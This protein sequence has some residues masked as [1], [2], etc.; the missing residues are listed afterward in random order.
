MHSEKCNKRAESCAF[1]KRVMEKFENIE[2]KCSPSNLFAV[3]AHT[4]ENRFSSDT[5]QHRPRK[6]P[7]KKL[8]AS[9]TSASL[10]IEQLKSGFR[11]SG[12]FAQ[13]T[14]RNW[15]PE[16]WI[17]YL[18]DN[19]REKESSA[20]NRQ[21][22]E[23]VKN[24]S[25]NL[26]PQSP[27][28]CSIGL[29]FGARSL[30]DDLSNFSS[31]NMIRNLKKRLNN[32]RRPIFTCKYWFAQATSRSTSTDVFLRA[33]KS[34]Q[35][36]PISRT[37]L[38]K[39]SNV[40]KRNEIPN[41]IDR[42]CQH[43]EKED[44][45]KSPQDNYA[46]GDRPLV[47]NLFDNSSGPGRDDGFR[48]KKKDAQIQ[49]SS[50]KKHTRRK[51]TKKRPKL[52]NEE[53]NDSYFDVD[54]CDSS[55]INEKSRLSVR[56]LQK[57]RGEYVDKF[58]AV[59]RQIEEITAALRETCCS[60]TDS[61]NNDEF[62]CS[63]DKAKP[64]KK[65][66]PENCANRIV[67]KRGT[68]V[69]RKTRDLTVNVTKVAEKSARH[70]NRKHRSTD[71][72]MNS[73]RNDDVVPRDC[74]FTIQQK[75]VRC[76][77][78]TPGNTQNCRLVRQISFDLDLTKDDVREFSL[79]DDTICLGDYFAMSNGYAKDSLVRSFAVES[80]QYKIVKEKTGET[81]ILN[82]IK[83]RID[84]DFDDLAERSGN[85][86]TEEFL[87]T[88][89]P[90]T[91]S[92]NSA[93]S[94]FKL[95]PPS[96][97]ASR[98]RTIDKIRSVP[99]LPASYDYSTDRSHIRDSKS[100]GCASEHESNK[101]STLSKYFSCAQLSLSLV[102]LDGNEHANPIAINDSYSS[103]NSNRY[104]LDLNVER[105]NLNSTTD[106]EYV[107]RY[108]TARQYNSSSEFPIETI[109]KT[110][111][112]VPVEDRRVFVKNPTTREHF[113]LGERKEGDNSRVERD[114][115]HASDFI[116]FETPKRNVG[117]SID[118]GVFSSSLID[119]YPPESSSFSAGKSELKKKRCNDDRKLVA[120]KSS[121][122]IF[123][124]SSDSSCT[125]N[126]LDRRVDDV[127]RDLTKNLILCE[128]RARAK[129]K[130]MRWAGMRKDPRCSR[131]TRVCKFAS[132][133]FHDT[134]HDSFI[135]SRRSSEDEEI[136]SLSTPSLLSDSENENRDFTR[137]H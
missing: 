48:V 115:R 92:D 131:H 101:T 71:L 29:R 88:V 89:S 25:R 86:T 127:V 65:R 16:F 96:G 72:S 30:S 107:A 44:A 40:F 80:K 95:T 120:G 26:I 41:V 13:R 52:M 37:S 67:A 31:Y 42:L 56:V 112:E 50:K 87:T 23:I 22:D 32:V 38:N 125:D 119:L 129:L 73:D 18:W 106:S 6:S 94:F 15:R 8:K 11:R 70:V 45:S 46:A 135:S 132:R 47:P 27:K 33:H 137:R 57:K 39:E 116:T 12:D 59:S 99:L 61:E 20:A 91:K 54:C 97:D 43:S 128:R 78:R 126:T 98:K 51:K 134:S 66:E 21:R 7:R 113:F 2:R 5:A 111:D 105:S 68:R 28:I 62:Y 123:D 103:S 93:R 110:N 108:D 130:E 4:R 14:R 58:T 69:K 124:F 109:N 19:C 24:R 10:V 83:R 55:E 85:D 118:S 100:H 117:G 79:E 81:I 3:R 53:E 104:D 122:L 60:E 36:T 121:S 102:S 9:R 90:K 77:G 1:A 82:D 75:T 64:E 133:R 49:T 63:F 34:H 35:S 84:R 74:A 114:E 17:R 76:S 136:V